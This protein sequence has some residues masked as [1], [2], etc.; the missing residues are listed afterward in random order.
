MCTLSSVEAKKKSKREKHSIK[1]VYQANENYH[2]DED[3]R[4]FVPGTVLDP[5]IDCYKACHSGPN[6]RS[7][8]CDVIPAAGKFLKD[9][10][11]QYENPTR[12]DLQSC[13][14]KCTYYANLIKS[15]F[16]DLYPPRYSV[17]W[18]WF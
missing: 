16:K 13:R 1:E 2:R 3:T 6:W 7:L 15:G 8:V 12:P 5:P 4:P 14:D 10:C 18:L 9:Y 11:K 17:A